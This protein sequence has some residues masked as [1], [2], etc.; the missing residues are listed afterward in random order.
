M[1]TDVTPVLT[2]LQE[3]FD[4][5]DAVVAEVELE[6]DTPAAGW[7]VR[8]TVAHLAGTDV[9]AVRALTD[10]EGFL[11]GLVVVARDI[12]GFLTSQLT[13]RRGLTKEELT[14]SWRDGFGRL[15][16]ALKA[17][18]H[19]P[20]PWYGPPMSPTSFATA[21]LMEYWA[22]GQDIADAA[23]VERTST[24]R[25]RHICHLGVRT[26]GFA[27]ANRGLT[28]PEVPVRVELEAP[29]GGLWTYGDGEQSVRGSALDFCLLVT[30]RRHRDD[31]ALVAEGAAADQWLDIAQCFAGPPG[32][33]RAPVA[34]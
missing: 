18:A 13:E 26:R 32:P 21:R 29:G 31:L 19:Q 7:D 24:E 1:A 11:A 20:V 3:E 2:D 4:D 28:A 10:P 5:L 9:E 16:A 22:H 23:G 8:D 12:E 27:Y 6:A 33:G 34:G 30:Q 15:L 17:P 14:T 25:L